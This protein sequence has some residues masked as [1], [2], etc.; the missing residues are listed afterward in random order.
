MSMSI[1]VSNRAAANAA[2]TPT[3]I[4]EDLRQIGGQTWKNADTPREKQLAS[5]YDH[6]L[7]DLSQMLGEFDS[8]GM[9]NDLNMS[10]SD[11]PTSSNPLKNLGQFNETIKARAQTPAEKNLVSK[12]MGRQR[13]YARIV[14]EMKARDMLNGD[15]INGTSSVHARP[16]SSAY[17]RPAY[18]QQANLNRNSQCASPVRPCGRNAIADLWNQSSRCSREMD[19]ETFKERLLNLLLALIFGDKSGRNSPWGMEQNQGV[20]RCCGKLRFA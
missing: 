17:T 9:F 16:A 3:V 1:A 7:K 11:R 18:H 15:E 12:W 8:L 13:D 20:Q 2:P 4:R 5:E 10:K 6:V 19:F 14:G